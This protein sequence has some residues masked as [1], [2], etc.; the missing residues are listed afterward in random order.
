VEVVTVGRLA[1]KSIVILTGNEFEDIEVLFPVV[2]FS[3]EGATVTV[4]TLPKE[5]PGHFTTRPYDAN[6]PITGR[7]GTTIPFVV[8]EE[9]KRWMHREIPQL[10][11]DDYDAVV[12]PGGFAPDALRLDHGVLSFVEGMHAAGKL[13]AAICHGP[14]VLISVDAILGTD[15]VR[16]RSVTCYAAVRDDILNAGA[17]F[18]EVPAVVSGNVITGR[19][20]DD[21]PDFCRAIIDYLLGDVVDGP[22][23]LG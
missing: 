20:P 11:V 15:L 5:A 4:A 17:K 14:Q 19:L 18:L 16:G 6:K 1:S 10:S 13:V 3:E 8:L 21:L 12:V 2:R 22:Y 23:E 7:F 9:G